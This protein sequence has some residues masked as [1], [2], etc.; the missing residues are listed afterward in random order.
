MVEMEMEMV[1]G[2]EVEGVIVGI[3]E[4]IAVDREGNPHDKGNDGG[5]GESRIQW[6]WQGEKEWKWKCWLW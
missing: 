3:E 6:V 2:S 4:F 1:V 5:V